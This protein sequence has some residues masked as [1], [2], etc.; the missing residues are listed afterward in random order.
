MHDHPSPRSFDDATLLQRG[1][2]RF[3]A[4]MPGSVVLPPLLHRLDGPVHRLTGGRHTLTSVLAGLP[5]ATIETIGARSGATR[6]LPLVVLPTPEGPAVI[7]SNYGQPTHPGWVH[8]LRA[9]P[10]GSV[11]L[12][13]R[14]WPFRAVELEGARRAR[15]WRDALTAHPGFARYER[16]AAPREIPVF[17]LESPPPAA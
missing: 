7:G 3:G 5:V 11:T 15:I 1:L 17:V 12:D 6:R 13:G 8:N 14:T 2:R 9:N 16:R 4:S 10:N